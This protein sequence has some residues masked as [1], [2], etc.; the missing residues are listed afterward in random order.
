M[1]TLEKVFEKILYS[2]LAATVIVILVL[3]LKKIFKEK[4]TPRFH[5]I[6]WLLVLTRLL[7]PFAPESNLS[8]FNFLP[9]HNQSLSL[10]MIIPKFEESMPL[11]SREST[12]NT[13]QPKPTDDV[14]Q[15]NYKK[16]ISQDK[17]KSEESIKDKNTNIFQGNLKLLSYIWAIG[18]LLI[19]LF[20][21]TATFKFRK[22]VKSFDKIKCPET[23]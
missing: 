6:I 2:S 17:L 4:F 8:L 21:L 18:V 13:I 16:Q 5:H 12:E 14:K 10:E 1:I 20:I 23:S 15:K 22:N 11:V 19:S 9:N 3:F 7:I